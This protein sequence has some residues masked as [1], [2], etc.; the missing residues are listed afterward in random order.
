ML[1][2][3]FLGDARGRSAAGRCRALVALTF[4]EK[5]AR[6]LRQRIRERCREQG[7]PPARNRAMA[8]GAARPGGRADRHVPRV[9]RA[10]AP[11]P[12]PSRSGSTPSSRSSTPRSRLRS[13]TRPCDR[14]CGGCWPSVDPDLIDL[15]L[16][17]GLHQI[18]EAL[19]A[20]AATRVAASLDDWTG[21]SAEELSTAGGNSGSEP[22]G[23]PPAGPAAAGRCVPSTAGGAAGRPPQAPQRRSDLLDALSRLEAGPCSDERLV[24]LA[25]WPGERPGCQ[26][27]LAGA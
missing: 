10:V 14:H 22:A 12:G 6:E 11:R 23:P 2:E 17:Y 8:N 21:L 19:A 4:T 25:A 15:A 1:T 13:A 16:D 9:L 20:L 5:A 27:H 7:S 18:R 3:R 26:G 24:E